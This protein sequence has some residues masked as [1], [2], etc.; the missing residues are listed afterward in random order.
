S[1]SFQIE[2][3]DSVHGAKVVRPSTSGR[4]IADSFQPRNQKL[5]D[6]QYSMDFGCTTE[7]TVNM[8]QKVCIKLYY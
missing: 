3:S 4:L 8:Q 1:S 2:L 5:Y 6:K 7:A